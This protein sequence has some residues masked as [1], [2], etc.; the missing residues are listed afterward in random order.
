MANKKGGVAA[1][2]RELAQPLA[3]RMG[4]E[5]WDVEYVREGAD[6]YLRIT[7]D[8][9]QGIT[10][11]DCEAFSRA[12]DPMLDEADPI[13]DAYHLEV[14]SPG[15]ERELKTPAHVAACEGWD[16]EA[17]L[18]SPVGGSRVVKGVLLG[19]DEDKN[20]HIAVSED[21]EIVLP[22]AAISRLCTVYDF[23]SGH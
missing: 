23:T 22:H 5:L 13:S 3:D 2:V 15:I 7:L 17:K 11:E 10:L 1:V 20:V 21:E 16:V 19:M 9:E 12:I 8:N 4:Y 14:S 18:F 6:Y